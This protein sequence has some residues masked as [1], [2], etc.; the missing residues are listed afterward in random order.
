[1]CAV[2]SLPLVGA[3]VMVNRGSSSLKPPG[4][5]WEQPVTNWSSLAI[6]SWV[7]LLTTVQN[8]ERTS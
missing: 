5:S 8:Q 6:S 3:G 1:M 7:K 4:G 2:G